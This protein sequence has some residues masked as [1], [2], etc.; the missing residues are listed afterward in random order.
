MTQ[1]DEDHDDPRQ[2]C[3]HGTFIGSWWGPD[4]LCGQCEMGDPDPTPASLREEADAYAK[5]F[6]ELYR[7]ANEM[8]LS[9][10]Q[11]LTEEFITRHKALWQRY[12]YA[13]SSADGPEDTDWLRKAHAAEIS[14]H[15]EVQRTKD[16]EAWE[17][18]TERTNR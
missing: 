8:G 4:Y 10:P 13:L 7:Q 1:Y 14:H 15:R 18:R 9:F 17:D 5:K 12:E 6:G 11:Q 2:R 16:E 3:K